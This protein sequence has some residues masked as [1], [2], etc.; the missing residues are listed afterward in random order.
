[1]SQAKEEEMDVTTMP[2]VDDLRQMAR[3]MF[4]DQRVRGDNDYSGLSKEISDLCFIIG[5]LRRL[6]A[7]HVYD[8][9]LRR[10]EL[11]KRGFLPPEDLE[12]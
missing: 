10:H 4:R 7:V 1:M 8:Q 6:D 5:E 3:E 2:S 9:E 12:A 11:L